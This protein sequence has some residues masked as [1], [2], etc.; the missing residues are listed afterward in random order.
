[1][2]FYTTGIGVAGAL[3]VALQLDETQNTG[4]RGA[5][6]FTLNAGASTA[7]VTFP[8][9]FTSGVTPIVVCTPPYQTSFWVTNI[10]NTGFTFNVGTTNIYAQTIRCIAMVSI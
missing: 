10:T 7:S 1:M 3:A 8:S 4:I 6:T 2:K 9:A 5:F